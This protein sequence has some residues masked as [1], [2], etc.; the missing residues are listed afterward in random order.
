[1]PIMS[2]RSS[3]RRRAT[4]PHRRRTTGTARNFRG[5]VAFL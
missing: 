4:Q 1:L 3:P 5:I 2:S